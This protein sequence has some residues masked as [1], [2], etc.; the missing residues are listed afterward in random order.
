MTTKSSLAERLM[1]GILVERGEDGRLRAEGMMDYSE[2]FRIERDPDGTWRATDGTG[3]MFRG[4]DS[5]ERVWL[6]ANYAY[7]IATEPMKGET[8]EEARIDSTISIKRKIRPMTGSGMTDLP[9]LYLFERDQKT[10]R[11]EG[12]LLAGVL[13]IDPIITEVVKADFEEVTISIIQ[14]LLRMLQAG[15]LELQTMGWMKGMAPPGDDLTEEQAIRTW[16]LKTTRVNVRVDD[17]GMVRLQ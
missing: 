15:E 12:F 6:M 11:R 5:E 13:A 1:R 14:S 16:S 9:L 17:V 10:E 4:L 2:H 3:V 8:P 7:A